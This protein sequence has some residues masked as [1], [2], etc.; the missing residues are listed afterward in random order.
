MPTDAFRDLYRD[1][2]KEETADLTADE[3]VGNKV[4][5]MTD[6]EFRVWSARQCAKGDAARREQIGQR[7]AAQKNPEPLTLE[8]LLSEECYFRSHGRRRIS[9][10]ARQDGHPL[11]RGA[12]AVRREFVLPEGERQWRMILTFSAA[13]LSS[14]AAG[15][16]SDRVPRFGRPS[17]GVR[18][19][20][21][22]ARGIAR[23]NA[24]R[25]AGVAR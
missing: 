8:E 20:N 9:G 13:R 17:P 25:W 5:E 3:T 7:L 2:V 23:P 6:Q 4:A 22:A 10:G 15:H 1:L 18:R 21:R 11:F 12:N 16:S 14:R 24:S 19:T